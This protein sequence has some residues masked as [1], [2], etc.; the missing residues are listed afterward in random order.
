MPFLDRLI[1]SPE[2]VAAYSLV[3]SIATTLGQSIYEQVS[4]ILA[5]PSAELA[6]THVDIGGTLNSLQ[7]A[8]IVE[9]VD[10]LR[11]GRR[12]ANKKNE[13]NEIL[14]ID[15]AGGKHEKR[16]AQVDFFMKRDGEEFYFE[17]K[18][19]KPNIGNFAEAKEKLLQWVARKQRPVQT[20][21]AFPYNPYEPEP[22]ARFTQQGMIDVEQELL[23]GP[24]TGISSQARQSTMT[25]WMSSQ[26]SE[27]TSRRE[28]CP[29][30]MK[31]AERRAGG[32]ELPKRTLRR[33]RSQSTASCPSPSCLRR[34]C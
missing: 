19:V 4:L 9:I 13:V 3:H 24:A 34:A 26:E 32:F 2:H 6:K 1:Q 22:Y 11:N 27:P 30:S 31:L 25:C 21:L 16:N 18:T 12:K 20:I 15:S 10:D 23:V 8:K 28:Y 7:N 5:R 14:S 29:S 17:I 33:R